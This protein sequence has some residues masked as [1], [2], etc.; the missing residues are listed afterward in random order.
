[1]DRYK[2]EQ[3]W[4]KFKIKVQEKWRK[5]TDEDV[6]KI[7]GDYDELMSRIQQRHGYSKDEAEREFERWDL[8]HDREEGYEQKGPRGT[9][10][11]EEERMKGEKSTWDEGQGQKWSNEGEKR[12]WSNEERLGQREEWNEEQQRRMREQKEGGQRGQGPDEKKKRRGW[13]D[14]GKDKRRK[15]G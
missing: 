10:F 11:E 8:Q 6:S 4:N 7:N 3:N 2:F 12:N 14:E 5:L 9:R 15:A 1:M 13:E